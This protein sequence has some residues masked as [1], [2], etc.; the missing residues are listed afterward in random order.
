MR[1][2]FPKGPYFL[3]SQDRGTYGVPLTTGTGT[4][5]T[6]PAHEAAK[7]KPLAHIHTLSKLRATDPPYSNLTSNYKQPSVVQLLLHVPAPYV[8]FRHL[9][10][11]YNC[12]PL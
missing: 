6:K 12:I 9:G 10:Q 8:I 2:I 11:H 7:T 4:G 3:L 1:F 5:G